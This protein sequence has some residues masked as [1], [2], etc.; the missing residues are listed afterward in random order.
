M[1]I[2][3]KTPPIDP[4]TISRSALGTTWKNTFFC[5]LPARVSFFAHFLVQ[6]W[7]SERAPKIRHLLHA[8]FTLTLGIN[9]V[10]KWRVV[11]HCHAFCV[12][13]H[14]DPL[15]ADSQTICA[16]AQFLSRSMKPPTIKNYLS[17]VKMLH[18]FLGF[19]YSH[20]DDFHLQLV[21]RGISR[22]H[23]HVP[24][25]A[26][27]ITPA[28]LLAFHQH[29][30]HDS[31][32]HCTV[33]ACC[34]L[35]FYTMARV[36]SIL[37]SSE[38]TATHTF[39]SRDRVNY[40]KEGL[41][42]TL[43]HTKTI[44]FGQR[45]LHIPLL[46]RNSVL[47]PVRAYTKSSSFLGSTLPVPAFAVREQG[48]TSWLTCS[49]FIDTFRTVIRSSG[50]AD[51]TSYTGHSFRRGGASW[52]FQAGV[53]GELIQICGDW[54]SDAYKRYLEFNMKNKIDLAALFSNGLP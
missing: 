15:P 52:A 38:R 18:I 44:Q 31:S 53:P 40:S 29:M 33:F 41:L 50:E 2:E 47:C 14:R 16:Y 48:L 27:P 24:H 7:V 46:T 37:P 30:D 26:K 54:A 45:R 11:V 20:S 23:P 42:V 25:R 35:L 21:L 39:L 9:R 19:E 6:K 5:V 34:L 43:L 4:Q 17:G 51:A 49:T 10:C 3:S 8:F 32:L 12:Y 28:I 22:L 36:G 1:Q 13:F